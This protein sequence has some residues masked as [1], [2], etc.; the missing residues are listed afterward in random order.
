ME[1]PNDHFTSENSKEESVISKSPERPTTS[2]CR[3]SNCHELVEFDL[4]TGREFSFCSN[5]N[6]MRDEN[7]DY[8]D[9]KSNQGMFLV[10]AVLSITIIIVVVYTECAIKECKN[11]CFVDDEGVVHECCCYTH[12]ME[13][14]RRM[15]LQMQG[16]CAYCEQL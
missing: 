10:H 14:H 15:S 4:N 6:L 12:A 9:Y 2:V 3:Q 11:E 5:H 13:H 8:E 16:A 7:E 1:L